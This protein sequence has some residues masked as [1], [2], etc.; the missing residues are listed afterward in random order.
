MSPAARSVVIAGVVLVAA[1]SWLAVQPGARR[2]PLRMVERA[3]PAPLPGR[4]PLARD[5]LASG[6]PLSAAQLRELEA[7]AAQWER[8]STALETDVRA[9]SAEFDRF[10]ATAQ[11]EGRTSLAEVRRRSAELR[12][13]SAELRARREVQ[14]DAALA[15]LTD[16]QRRQ[17]KT[18]PGGM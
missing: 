15:V 13:L 12:E 8:E 6:I 1:V 10:A 11:A 18:P 7:L 3:A 17:M 16:A 14:S 4:P 9:A 5:V 2:P